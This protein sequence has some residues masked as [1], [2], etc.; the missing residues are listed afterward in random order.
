[1]RSV[2]GGVE[3]ARRGRFHRYASHSRPLRV[4]EGTS[5]PRPG[6][7]DDPSRVRAKAGGERRVPVRSARPVALQPTFQL[8]SDDG[9][10]KYEGGELPIPP[11][12][13]ERAVKLAS[14]AVECVPGLLGY[15]GVDLVL[16]EAEDGSRDYAIEINRAL[17]TS[18]IGCVR[19][20]DF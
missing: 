8:L 15:V 4:G 7:T 17:T 10:F 19:S 3:A 18:Y 5:E 16:G 13:A 12:L 2:S 6:E 1:M 20:A 9:R 11:T 14:R